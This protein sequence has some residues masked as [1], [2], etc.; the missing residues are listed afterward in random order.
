[1]HLTS[2]GGKI[3]RDLMVSTSLIP[4]HRVAESVNNIIGKT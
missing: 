3:L 1:M 4:S 2:T